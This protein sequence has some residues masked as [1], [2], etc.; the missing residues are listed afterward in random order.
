MEPFSRGRYDVRAAQDAKDLTLAQNLR[1]RAFY[2]AR[3]RARADGRDTDDY[4]AAATHVIVLDRAT[5]GSVACFRYRLWDAQDLAQSYSA[6]W[7]D[8]APLARIGGPLIEIGRLCLDP[9]QTS[10]DPMRLCM[11]AIARVVL[12]QG[13]SAMFGC[14]SLNGADPAAHGPILGQLAGHIGPADRLP[15][16]KAPQTVP[17]PET[18]GAPPPMPPLLQSYLALGGWVSDH[19]VIDSHFDTLHVLTVV[20]IAKIPPARVRALKLL[21]AD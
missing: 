9:D 20:E 4:D 15:G 1:Y 2:T 14:A 8:L 17:F 16:Q 19:A 13:V 12:G 5:G 18:P 10:P 7:Y 6:Q 21:A 3:G 11:A